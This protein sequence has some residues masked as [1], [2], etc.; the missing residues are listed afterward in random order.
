MALWASFMLANHFE[1]CSQGSFSKGHTSL[2]LSRF[3][4]AKPILS[5]TPIPG[6]RWRS[7]VQRAGGGGSSLAPWLDGSHPLHQYVLQTWQ[8]GRNSKLPLPAPNRT[9]ISNRVLQV[10]APR[11]Y[12]AIGKLTGPRRRDSANQGKA[13]TFARVAV[14]LFVQELQADRHAA[15]GTEYVTCHLQKV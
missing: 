4:V 12:H 5:G 15:Y 14:S 10:D 13:A 8:K 2:Y 7:D 6:C 11:S 9:L 1:G 3:F